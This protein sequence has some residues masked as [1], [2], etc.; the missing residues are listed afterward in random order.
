MYIQIR[1]IVKT[2]IQVFLEVFSNSDSFPIGIL[3]YFVA[4]SLM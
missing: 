4:I 1:N 2:A 3:L